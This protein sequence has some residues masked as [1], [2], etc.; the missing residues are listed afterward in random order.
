MLLAEP[1]AAMATAGLRLRSW[2]LCRL[3]GN[4]QVW[5]HNKLGVVQVLHR[6]DEHF[7]NGQNGDRHN[8]LPLVTEGRAKFLLFFCDEW[9]CRKTLRKYLLKAG[10]D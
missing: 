3:G 9:Q 5:V 4:R 2:W 6:Q 1:A 10:D 8:D 7:T